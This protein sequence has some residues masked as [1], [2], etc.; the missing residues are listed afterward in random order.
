MC[1]KKINN[2][3]SVFWLQQCT[4]HN[5]FFKSNVK[6]TDAHQCGL[7]LAQQNL[8]DTNNHTETII[9]VLNRA[10][11]QHEVQYLNSCCPEGELKAIAPDL[12]ANVC[13]LIPIC[14]IFP[15]APTLY[16]IHTRDCFLK[17][18]STLQ[19]ENNLAVSEETKNTDGNC[20]LGWTTSETQ[21]FKW[22]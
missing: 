18:I 4:G 9:S 13:L 14:H 19:F 15:F 7:P 2:T 17:L 20:T 6:N 11:I 10:M 12:P 1:S 16:C 8:Y 3:F 21:G 22:C 5:F